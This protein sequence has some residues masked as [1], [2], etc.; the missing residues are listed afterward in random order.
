M[1]SSITET[2]FAWEKP[3]SYLRPMK[4]DNQT[5]QIMHNSLSV[6]GLTTKLGIKGEGNRQGKRLPTC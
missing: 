4:F 3:N 6:L 2:S 1:N 5:M